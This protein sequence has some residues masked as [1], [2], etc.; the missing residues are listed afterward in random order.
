MESKMENQIQKQEAKRSKS[1]IKN[2]A[3][4]AS[5]RIYSTG[6]KRASELLDAAND[7]EFGRSVKLPE[8]FELAL[9][10]VTSDH[11]RQLQDRSATNEDRKEHL[12]QVYIKKHG[13]ISKDDF[14]G[15]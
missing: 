8:L 9:S 10:L 6:K 2:A 1:K 12:R 7:K 14:T 5:V 15:F 4:C 11:I 13:Q 3:K